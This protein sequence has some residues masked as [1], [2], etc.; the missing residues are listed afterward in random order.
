MP[1]ETLALLRTSWKTHR[2]TTWLFPATG[3]DP[4]HRAAAASPLR[5]PS[6]PG[7]FRTAKH[8]AGITTTG[9]AIH[10]LRPSYATPLL[11]AGVHPRLI[12]HSLG[13]TQL[14]TTMVSL[15]LT[16]KGH[17]EA[18]ERLNALMHG[19]RP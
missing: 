3:R 10:P 1:E 8:R 16:H 6:V 12:Q 17:E 11:E 5:R 18:Y 7:A 4:K 13:H 9:V 2:N 15:H 14:E 19:L